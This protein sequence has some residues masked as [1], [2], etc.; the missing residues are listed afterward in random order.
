MLWLIERDINLLSL[1]DSTAAFWATS[2]TLN[3]GLMML[4]DFIIFVYP[5]PHPILSDDNP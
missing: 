4:R 5:Y 1:R 3:G 2:L